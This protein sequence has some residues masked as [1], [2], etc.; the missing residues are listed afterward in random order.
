ML[1]VGQR[2]SEV[3][4]VLKRRGELQAP[5]LVDPTRG[6]RGAPGGQAGGKRSGKGKDKTSG[7][8]KGKTKSKAR[9]VV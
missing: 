5:S 9:T 7:K 2:Y 3:A 6:S 1:G 4:Q 8:G